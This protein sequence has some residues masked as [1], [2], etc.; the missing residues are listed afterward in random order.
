MLRLELRKELLLI[1]SARVF[2]VSDADA[3]IYYCDDDN[4]CTADSCDPGTGDC[5]HDPTPHNGDP[6]DDGDLCTVR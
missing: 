5:I 6:C 2:I 4:V 3:T 1:M